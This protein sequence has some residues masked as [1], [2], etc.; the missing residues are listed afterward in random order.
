MAHRQIVLT[1]PKMLRVYFRYD[2]RLLGE[3]CRVAAE[4]LVTSFRVMLGMPSAEPGLV[5]CVHSFGNLLNFHPHLHVMAI[6][7]GFTPE[8]VFHPL[9]TVSLAMGARR[10]GRR[11]TGSEAGSAEPTLAVADGHIIVSLSS[12]TIAC[13]SQRTRIFCIV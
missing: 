13:T 6:D 3:L 1:I 11:L 10:S 7:G 2:R 9:P 12:D 5:V 8:G 4:V